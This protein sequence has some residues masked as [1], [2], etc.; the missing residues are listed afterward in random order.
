MNTLT[1]NEDIAVKLPV[2]EG[3]LDLLLYLIRKD[4]LDIYDIPIETVTKQ[5]IEIIREMEKTDLEL[6]GDFFVMAAT[7][8]YIKSRL[9]LP[10][11]DQLPID[12]DQDEEVDPRWEL[13]QQL[14]EYKKF[15][16]AS[17]EIDRLIIEQSDYLPRNFKELKED[18]S[19]RKLAP[20]DKVEM[21]NIFNQ[22]LRRLSENIHHGKIHDETVTIADRMEYILEILKTKDTFTLTDLVSS[23]EKLSVSFLVASFL[24]ILE[25]GK[26]RFIKIR[27]D[28]VYG[29]IYCEK[30]V[31]EINEIEAPEEI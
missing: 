30:A 31:E 18:I 27:Q 7:L 22:V 4:E 6:A 5:Y 12:S 14:I 9:L 10:K 26:Q 24:A 17:S 29:E 25:M 11:K 23:E 20:T 2:F 16:V 8:M 1:K 28:E 3:P 15:K 21:W 19:K 13:V